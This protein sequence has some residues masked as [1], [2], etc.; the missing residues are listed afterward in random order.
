M[1]SQE[2]MTRTNYD[3]NTDNFFMHYERIQNLENRN[4]YFPNNEYS[5]RDFVVSKDELD[6][7]LEK[8][9]YYK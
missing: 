1:V 8:N 6:K 9:N 4:S 2:E 5:S 7:I 3:S